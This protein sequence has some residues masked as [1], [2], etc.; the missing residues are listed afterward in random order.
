MSNGTFHELELSG[1]TPVPLMA[2]LKALGILRLVSEQEDREARGW[3]RNDTF[4]LR[5]KLD[6]DA[7]LKFFREQYEPTA[8]IAPWGARSGF[9]SESS[10]KTA[11]NAQEAILNDSTQRLDKFR[12]C[13]KLMRQLLKEARITSKQD[14]EGKLKL[15]RLCRNSL[16]DE[17]IPW[18]DTCVVLT[19]DNRRYP[20]LLG[21]GGNE[22]S[23]SYVSGFAQQIIE[24]VINHKHDEALRISLFAGCASGILHD[25]TPGHFSPSA[26]G[27][28][29]GTQGFESGTKTNPWDYLLCIEGTLLW[30]SAAVRRFGSQERGVAAFPFTVK[31]CGSGS[32][33]LSFN[34]GKKPVNAKREIAEMWLPVW[35]RH[36]S[37]LEISSILSE[38][39]VSVGGRKAAT[40]LDMAQAASSLGIDRGIR[41]FKRTAFLMRNGQ[42]FLSVPMGTFEVTQRDRV[43]LLCQ[44]NNKWLERFRKLVNSKTVPSRLI[45]VMHHIDS[46]IF[47]FCK[48]GGAS[49]LQKV[50]IAL[51]TVERELALTEGKIGKERIRPFPSLSSEWIGASDD[52]SAEFA[53]AR[54]VASISDP[55][56]KIGPLR[57]NLEPVVWTKRGIEWCEKDRSIVWNAADLKTNL[58]NVLQRRIMDGRRFGCESIPIWSRFPVHLHEIAR[59]ISQELDDERICELIWGMMLIRET[60]NKHEMHSSIV[61]E[62]FQ[63][64]GQ[65]QAT[66]ISVLRAYALLKLLFLTG[67]LVGDQT[68]K[69]KTAARLSNYDGQSEIIIPPEPSI[70]HLLRGRRIGEACAIAMRRLRASSLSPIP[71][72][73]RSRGL[74]DNDWRELDHAGEGIIDPL[75]LTAALLI[76]ISSDAVLKLKSLVIHD[77]KIED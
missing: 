45:S 47:D 31:V 2:Y 74:R 63:S 16:P 22:G 68:T 27:G 14:D 37:F 54:A 17:L 49:F 30:A 57:S 21:T 41:Q 60:A 73:I 65:R 3:W 64:Q 69:D 13:I 26:A 70:P 48:H 35:E 18:L 4:W 56:K 12:D 67:P 72:P 28:A 6:K 33:S 19:D 46:A 15:I 58:A 43:D 10:E 77:D 52:G 29:N 1:C 5:S 36:L 20:P 38:G 59:F 71:R 55:E 9:Y 11:R 40:A 34:D 32:P 25:Q 23:G 61:K 24:C 53:I 51:G 8:I 39:R 44:I 7:L 76:P 66:G 62:S 50:L 42:A 75:R